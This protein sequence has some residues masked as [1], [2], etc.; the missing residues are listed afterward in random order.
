MLDQA[1]LTNHDLPVSQETTPISPEF[2]KN[3]LPHP[4]LSFVAGVVLTLVVVGGVTYFGNNYQAKNQT[5]LIKEE[6]K[7]EGSLEP[8]AIPSPMVEDSPVAS[9]V[10]YL[11]NTPKAYKLT[12]IQEPGSH[13]QRPDALL[14]Y[15]LNAVGFPV[16]KVED[17]L[18]MSSSLAYPVSSLYGKNFAYDDIFNQ[19][20]YLSTPLTLP[21]AVVKKNLVTMK[22][23]PQPDSLVPYLADSNYC[24]TDSDCVIRSNF[25]GVGVFNKYHKYEDIWGCAGPSEIVGVPIE[26]SPFLQ[27]NTPDIKYANIECVGNKCD[28]RGITW[29][30]PSTVPAN[31]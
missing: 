14:I 22:I 5:A 25:C 18:I 21:N 6:E 11:S 2:K 4:M 3:K 31:N 16:L 30:C 26:E 28:G 17:P 20:I 9:F 12:F 1:A 19:S 10:P 29:S 7:P 27:C 8:S 24:Q 23:E 13:V 15:V